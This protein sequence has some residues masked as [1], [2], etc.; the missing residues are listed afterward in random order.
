[1]L[2]QLFML[3]IRRMKYH[4]GCWHILSTWISRYVPMG[5]SE[6]HREDWVR[7]FQS[8]ICGG[9]L[10]NGGQFCAIT[11]CKAMFYVKAMPPVCIAPSHE[12]IGTTT[13]RL[14]YTR[15]KSLW[16][17]LDVRLGGSLRRFGRGGEDRAPTPAGNRSQGF[18]TAT[19]HF[20]DWAIDA[21][22]LYKRLYNSKGRVPVLNYVRD[23]EVS[24][25]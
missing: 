20:T 15:Q 3:H 6:I 13:L 23:E 21:I 16:C 2:H 4:D 7:I 5:G 24:C 19:S 11:L 10:Q 12:G 1:M 25:A 9:Y 17:P 14:L 8:W 22:I 18:P